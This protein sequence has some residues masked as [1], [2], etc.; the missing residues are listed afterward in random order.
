VL[1]AG[2]ANGSVILTWDKCDIKT[3]ASGWEAIVAKN[4][5]HKLTDHEAISG[6]ILPSGWPAGF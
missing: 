4:T 2:H 6:R 3:Q 1:R 5:R